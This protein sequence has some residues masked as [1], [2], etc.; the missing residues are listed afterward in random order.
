MKRRKIAVT[1]T[2][3]N[4]GNLRMYM[5]ELKQFFKMHKGCRV[6]A[7]FMVESQ[8]SSEALKGYYYNCVVPSFQEGMWDAGERLTEE[9]AE[10]KN[11]AEQMIFQT[12]KSLNELGDNLP[13][14]KKAPIEAALGKLKEAHKAQ[15]ID[16]IEPA[17]KELETA[18]HAASQ[19]MYQAQQQAG[20]QAGPQPGAQPNAGNQG[21]D[22]VTDVDF[23]EV[24]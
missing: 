2:I 7:K 4:N 13:A 14:D 8:G 22:N 19:E 17:M 15:D 6:I 3:D 9:E 18:F 16:A 23:E 20:T 21:G 5:D 11:E 24:K 12:E 1:G 10:I